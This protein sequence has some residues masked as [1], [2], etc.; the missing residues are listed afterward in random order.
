[1][2]DQA[3]EEAQDENGN[4]TSALYFYDLNND[5]EEYRGDKYTLIEKINLL[6]TSQ[7]NGLVPIVQ[8]YQM[9]AGEQF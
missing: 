8:S 4:E 1:M 7:I 6:D 2:N 3:P 5:A 9:Q